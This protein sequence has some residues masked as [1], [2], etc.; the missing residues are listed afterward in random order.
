MGYCPKISPFQGHISISTSMM[1]LTSSYRGLVEDRLRSP[2]MCRGKHCSTPWTPWILGKLTK[3]A[4][5]GAIGLETLGVTCY[6]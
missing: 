6:N 2:Q 3:M 1:D 5:G 4:T